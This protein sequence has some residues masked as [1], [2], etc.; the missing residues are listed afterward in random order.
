MTRGR[1]ISCAVVA[2]AVLW[3]AGDAVGQ[4]RLI[5]GQDGADMVLVPAGAFWMGSQTEDIQLRVEDC[6]KSVKP[7][8]R[9]KCDEWFRDEGPQRQVFL[10]A[11][12][13]DR[14]EVTNALFERFV[15]RNAYRTTAEAEGWAGCS[16]PATA[17]GTR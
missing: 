14:Y 10:D 16:S 13:L 15:A 5:K 7:E 17:S 9:D 1:A 2:L 3:A 11:F 12:Y 6:K 8:N 4:E